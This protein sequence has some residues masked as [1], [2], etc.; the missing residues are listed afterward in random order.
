[1]LRPRCCIRRLRRKER[2][3]ASKATW[4]AIRP[5]CPKRDALWRRNEMDKRIPPQVRY[6]R[7]WRLENVACEPY[8]VYVIANLLRF[9]F[10]VAAQEEDCTH[11]R[12]MRIVLSP[13]VWVVSSVCVFLY[14]Y[15]SVSC[16]R[17]FST[18]GKSLRDALVLPR[19]LSSRAR[20][21]DAWLRCT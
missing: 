8:E 13:S 19:V 16:A 9:G 6:G 12:R 15:A 17:A 4:E 11:K 20:G 14:I 10:C 1:M 3:R 5:L 7:V 18:H 2:G 21:A